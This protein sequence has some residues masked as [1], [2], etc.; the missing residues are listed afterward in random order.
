MQP[1][2]ATHSPKHAFSSSF[3]PRRDQ[4]RSTHTCVTRPFESDPRHRTRILVVFGCFGPVRLAAGSPKR[5]AQKPQKTCFDRKKCI[6]FGAVFFCSLD[7]FSSRRSRRLSFG[8]FVRRTRSCFAVGSL[9]GG[10]P[11]GAQMT[12]QSDQLAFHTKKNACFSDFCLCLIWASWPCAG[13]AVGAR[14]GP[15]GGPSAGLK[16]P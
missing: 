6:L 7:S 15:K 2:R 11:K 1:G 8:G 9:A 10:P 4:T 3:G 14:L 16:S 5:G 13:C 12:T